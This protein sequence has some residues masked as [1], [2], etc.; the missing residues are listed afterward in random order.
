[1]PM[2]SQWVSVPVAV[3]LTQGADG[4]SVTFKGVMLSVKGPQAQVQALSIQ[5]LPLP[6]Q[7]HL[8]GAW[9]LHNK[10]AHPLFGGRAQNI[11]AFLPVV[12]LMRAEAHEC[13]GPC[14]TAW[15]PHE[16]HLPKTPAHVS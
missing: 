14:R 3:D 9:P 15:K 10:Q 7:V 16:M 5:A 11:P 8:H 2:N 13:G 12:R 6:C 1:M 4:Y